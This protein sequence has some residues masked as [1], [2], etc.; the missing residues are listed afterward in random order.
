MIAL[1]AFILGI[2]LWDHYFGQPA[3][4][5]PGT[6]QVAL[7][8]I[9][10]D[11]RLA[12]AMAEDPVW[13][14]R[15]VGVNDP[16]SARSIAVAT[17]QNLA[18][19]SPVSMIGMEA[20]AIIKAEN[21]GLPVRETIARVLQGQIVSDF[22]ATSRSLANHQGTWWHARLIEAWEKTMRPETHWR[23]TFGNDSRTLR[24]RAI[25]V[26]SATWLLG[27][28]G[29]LFIPRTLIRLKSAL[30][31]RPRGYGGAWPLSLGLTIFLVATLAWIG[32]T[33]ALEV[34]ISTLPH[35]HPLVAIFLDSSARLL[36]ALIALGLIFRRP[37][38]ALRV[39]GL[40]RPFEIRTILG[41]FSLLML[42]DQLL[43]WT[44]LGDASADPGA[45]LSPGEAGLWGLAFAVTSAC[46]LAPL[47]EELLYRGILFRSCW[48][49]LGVIPAA[50]ISSAVFAVLHFYD[51]YGLASVATFGFT[52]A[53][54]YAAT[55]S[56]GA[57]VSLHL[58]YNSSI[59]IPEWIIYHAP[60]D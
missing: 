18:K 53:I 32:F 6:E 20:F 41:V 33:L 13:L 15:L 38:H 16:E 42:I 29:L 48:N 44:L 25:I 19:E 50:L 5:A 1:L 9:D 11:L 59:K 37:S 47:S 26:R 52:A 46:L 28:A 17:L 34:G 35:L 55:G 22:S 51:G 12:D 27:I 10:R 56:L 24:S 49:R 7:V 23:E 31:A 8:K 43:R 58:L 4:Y 45:G 60:L 30:H 14:K 39:L 54:L 57:T 21:E 40:N 2:W 36:P 3:G